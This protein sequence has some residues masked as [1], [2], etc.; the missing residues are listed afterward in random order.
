MS[1]KLVSVE[2]IITSNSRNQQ[3]INE[4]NKISFED[5]IIDKIMNNP[6]T[7]KEINKD[8]FIK[9]IESKVENGKNYIDI[10]NLH[11]GDKENM[12]IGELQDIFNPKEEEK[13][14]KE[15]HFEDKKQEEIENYNG[16]LRDTMKYFNQD[17]DKKSS[18][19]S[20]D[21]IYPPLQKS[22]DLDFLSENLPEDKNREKILS[23]KIEINSKPKYI[24]DPEI[25]NQIKNINKKSEES[26][27]IKPIN[28]F[29]EYED[30]DKKYK[31][32]EGK[33]YNSKG[34]YNNFEKNRKP[35]YNDDDLDKFVS[36]NFDL[37]NVVLPMNHKKDEIQGKENQDV[38]SK[39]IENIKNKNKLQNIEYNNRN[40]IN[41]YYSKDYNDDYFYSLYK[42]FS[43]QNKSISV[44]DN[45][46][47][48]ITNKQK[49]S[50]GINFSQNQ[51]NI[52]LNR[53]KMDSG[54]NTNR[55]NNNNLYEKYGINQININPINYLHEY[56]PKDYNIRD[57]KEKQ[58][59]I[60]SLKDELKQFA[61]NK[62]KQKESREKNSGF[63]EVDER[64]QQ[65]YKMNNLESKLNEDNN[66]HK[67]DDNIDNRIE[68]LTEKIRN[69]KDVNE[70]YQKEEPKKEDKKL[71]DIEKEEINKSE[72]NEKKKLSDLLKDD[73]NNGENNLENNGENNLEN[74]GENNLE[75][76]GENNLE[77]NKENNLENNGENNLEKNEENNL[78]KN[79]ENNLEKKEE[80]NLEKKEENNLEKNDVEKNEEQKEEHKTIE[81]NI[82]NNEE[83]EQN[84]SNK[85][86]ENDIENNKQEDTSPM[87]LADIIK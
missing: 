5:F 12:K 57:P 21:L 60:E 30:K 24:I 14:N 7:Q 47:M 58:K 9:E 34:K 56:Q 64:L 85:N 13:E 23:S 68:S 82:K 61:I 75:N 84:I 18:L 53:M 52:L 15:F 40:S 72:K 63:N 48:K 39:K 59:Y 41:N 10:I 86:E 8:D 25:F 38:I 49:E 74:N 11:F 51:P 42:D 62:D 32:Y 33:N 66:D 31:I 4:T 73:D 3:N 28:E 78:E 35:L 77:N 36:V 67:I 17:D 19:P 79:E 87:L 45:K 37:H 54:Y 20:I 50:L 16:N 69:I 27:V 55:N 1:D 43:N 44:L 71:N 83:K 76:N 26:S 2:D 70:K 81:S 80:N 46:I 6:N 65:L 29:D 22:T